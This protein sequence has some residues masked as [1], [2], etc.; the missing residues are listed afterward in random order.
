MRAY[1]CCCCTLSETTCGRDKR[2]GVGGTLCY[3]D[4]FATRS[5]AFSETFV[6]G[7]TCPSE[8]FGIVFLVKQ[9]SKRTCRFSTADKRPLPR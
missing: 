8:Y 3:D 9:N 1:N 6:G 2:V 4:D 7:E 5:Y